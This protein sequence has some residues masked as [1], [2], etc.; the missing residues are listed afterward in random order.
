MD[1][2]L[3]ESFALRKK[4]GKNVANYEPN[5]YF[6]IIWSDKKSINKFY[7]Y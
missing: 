4:G 5:Y 7:V 6:L 1:S 3:Q 2:V